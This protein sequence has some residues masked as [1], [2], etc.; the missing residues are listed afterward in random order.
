MTMVSSTPAKPGVINV[1]DTGGIS[2]HQQERTGFILAKVRVGRSIR[3]ARS[4][5]LK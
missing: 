2:L 5:F 1:E 4:N 3:L